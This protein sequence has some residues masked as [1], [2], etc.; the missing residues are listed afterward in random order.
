MFPKGFQPRKT[1]YERRREEDLWIMKK[2]GRVADAARIEAELAE[3]RQNQPRTD[4]YGIPL[5]TA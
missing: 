2:A 3:L 1:Q 4:L 5:P